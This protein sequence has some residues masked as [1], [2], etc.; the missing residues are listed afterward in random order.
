MLIFLLIAMITAVIGEKYFKSA[1]L[2]FPTIFIVDILYFILFY[3]LNKSTI[4]IANSGENVL[5]LVGIIVSVLTGFIMLVA[6]LNFYIALGGDAS[7]FM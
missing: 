4:K 6:S 3:N 7:N 5:I 2:I 1:N